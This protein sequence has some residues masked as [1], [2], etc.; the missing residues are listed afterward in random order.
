[1]RIPVVRNF[2]SLIWTG[3]WP[4]DELITVIHEGRF[5]SSFFNLYNVL[6]WIGQ[7][8]IGPEIHSWI[9]SS[10]WNLPTRNCSLAPRTAVIPALPPG[11][12]S[13]KY[14]HVKWGIKTV[15]SLMIWHS[16]YN[17]DECLQRQSGLKNQPEWKSSIAEWLTDLPD[18]VSQSG[19]IG[20]QLQ[21][22]RLHVFLYGAQG[23]LSLGIRRQSLE[24]VVS[25]LHRRRRSIAIDCVV[26]VWICL[27]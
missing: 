14:F 9:T 21:L 6:K 8:I 12:K 11:Y 27:C 2:I 22:G 7:I 17:E 19:R 15:S 24:S 4:Q 20:L 3:T 10:R 25:A 23:H 5:T 18:E 16:R 1:M 26:P 13:G